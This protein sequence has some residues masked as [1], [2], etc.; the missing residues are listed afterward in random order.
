MRG[1]IYG[2]L[3]CCV[4][5][6][7][8]LPLSDLYVRFPLNH[9][10]KTVLTTPT[11][12]VLHDLRLELRIRNSIITNPTELAEKI[13]SYF[14]SNGAELV[15]QKNHLGNCSNSQSEISLCPNT[16]FIHAEVVSL[17]KGLKG[18]HSSGYDDIITCLVKKFIQ[19]AKKPLTHI[20]NIFLNSGVFPDEWKIAS[21]KPLYKKVDRH[22]IQNYKPISV[23]L[24]FF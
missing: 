9:T 23:Y 6:G 5:V 24:F 10:A 13:H 12:V 4:A 11:T 22:G 1:W 16:I 8:V 15:K 3:R 19:L 17:T 18:K 2:R 21:V 20:Y 7:F 14:T